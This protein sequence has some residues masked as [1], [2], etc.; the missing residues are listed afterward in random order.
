M[1][2]GKIEIP[3]PIGLLETDSYSAKANRVTSATSVTTTF[4][5]TITHADGSQV[6]QIVQD[7]NGDREV[8]GT[9]PRCRC[10][11]RALLVSPYGAR[12]QRSAG[13][14]RRTVVGPRARSASCPRRP[15]LLLRSWYARFLRPGLEISIDPL[16][17]SRV[18]GAG[19]EP[20]ACWRDFP[21]PGARLS[22]V[23]NRVAAA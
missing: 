4:E 6:I 19:R 8:V 9:A 14:T 3:P 23:H 21:R 17:F 15:S 13:A 2:E 5:Y 10:A 20:G 22:L 7:T 18:R 16:V 11:A 1:A 12:G